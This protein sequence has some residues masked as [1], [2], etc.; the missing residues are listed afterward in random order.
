MRCR[1]QDNYLETRCW[2]LCYKA[3]Q[4]ARKLL[5]VDDRVNRINRHLS[6]VDFDSMDG[7][8]V[9]GI[10]AIY[11]YLISL[12]V[13]LH[14]ALEIDDMCPLIFRGAGPTTPRWMKQHNTHR[15]QASLGI[16]VYV[17]KLTLFALMASD[18]IG[19]VVVFPFNFT[20]DMRTWH[21]YY[22]TLHHTH[23]TH[24]T[25]THHTKHTRQTAFERV[26]TDVLYHVIYN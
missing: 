25:H 5:L 11:C 15:W 13:S 26:N 19:L 16:I 8:G 1:F 20:G 9:R 24:N 18:E 14:L 7:K 12:E 23:H 2:P 3:R 4:E 21:T 6:R 10:M 22:T 17:G